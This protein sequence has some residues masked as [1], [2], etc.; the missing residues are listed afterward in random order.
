VEALEGTKP[1]A[2]EE[3]KQK[4]L[5]SGLEMSLIGCAKSDQAQAPYIDPQ[6]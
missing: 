1:M 3:N 2:I 4:W 5:G 6:E